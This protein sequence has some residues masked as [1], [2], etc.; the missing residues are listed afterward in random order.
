M[1]NTRAF[2]VLRTFFYSLTRSVGA[3]CGSPHLRNH[4]QTGCPISRVRCEKW[5]LSGVAD[6]SASS[7]AAFAVTRCLLRD[8]TVGWSPETNYYDADGTAAHFSQRTRE[9]G[10][11]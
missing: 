6:S 10:H 5:G 1:V 9:M 3:V 4:Q 8:D 2:S 7:S 11:P